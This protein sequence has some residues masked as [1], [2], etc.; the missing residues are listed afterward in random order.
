MTHFE[1]ITLTMYMYI[2]A[3]NKHLPVNPHYLAILC[4]SQR[5][6]VLGKTS[7]SEPNESL[8]LIYCYGTM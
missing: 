6:W 8:F 2:S 4:T 1:K 3:L 7:I 5:N